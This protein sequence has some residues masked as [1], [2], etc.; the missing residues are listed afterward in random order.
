MRERHPPAMNLTGDL[1]RLFATSLYPFRV[2]IAI[3]VVVAVLALLVVARRRGWFATARRHPR[4]AASV[5]AVALAVGLP[6]V[7]YLASPLVI[8]TEL[9]EPAPVGLIEAPPPPAPVAN[10]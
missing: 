6:V 8:R 3:G 4:R 1:E 7:W 2:P 9:I 10:P 5:T